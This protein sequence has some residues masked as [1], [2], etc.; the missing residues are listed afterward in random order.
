MSSVLLRG[1]WH[2]LRR[3]ACLSW[4]MSNGINIEDARASGLPL[5]PGKVVLMTIAA[6]T[7]CQPQYDVVFEPGILLGQY[8]AF[9]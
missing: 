7:S 2:Y 1:V 4:V 8:I 9:P 5:D 6:E 3:V